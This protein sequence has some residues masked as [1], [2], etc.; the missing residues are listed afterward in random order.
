MVYLNKCFIC[1]RKNCAFCCWVECSMVFRSGKIIVLLK[2][3]VC[4]LIF[5]LLVPS[6]T[7]R[8]VLKSSPF[9]VDLSLSNFSSVSFCIMEWGSLLWH[10]YTLRLLFFYELYL[11]LL[12]NISFYLWKHSLS[13]SL[14]Y[15]LLKYSLYLII[16]VH[17]VL[18]FLILCF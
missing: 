6:I 1:N 4:L 17:F 12:W 10:I 15:L 2:L 3:P 16:K 8:R 18:T 13:C 5:Y 14:F 9:I 11:L 7:G